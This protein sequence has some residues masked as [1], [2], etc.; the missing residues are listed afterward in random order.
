MKIES[1]RIENLRSIKDETVYLD[2]YTCLVGAN[3]AGKSNIINALN[4]F[5]HESNDSP[6]N[7]VNLDAE[8]FH[9]KNVKEPIIITLTFVELSSEAIND[10]QHY[11]RQEK[12]IIMAKATF[13][14]STQKASVIQYGLRLGMSAFKEYFEADKR[15]ASASELKDIYNK[16]RKEFPDLPH[17]RTKP[18]ME[19]NLKEYE[20]N[21]KDKCELIP[22]EDI[23]YGVSKGKNRLENHIQWIF[24]PAV[25]DA[26]AEQM[27]AKNTALGRLLSR[28][29]RAKT[30]FTNDMQKIKSNALDAYQKVLESNQVALEEISKS[31][32]KRIEE[33]AH[34]NASLKLAWMQDPEKSINISD[35]FAKIIAGEGGFEGEICRFGHGL[36]RSFLLALLQE[37]AS[38]DDSKNPKLILACEEPELYQH[39]PQIRHM[40]NLLQGLSEHNS[41]VIVCTH[42]PS[43]V[44]GKGFECV[45]MI[46][47]SKDHSKVCQATI[48]KINEKITGAKGIAPVQNTGMMAKI[49]QALQPGINEIFFTTKPILVEGVEDVAYIVTYLNLMGF[50]NDFRKYGCHIINVNGKSN[51]IAPVAILQ[52]LNIPVFSVF[53]SDGHLKAETEAEKSKKEKQKKDNM[54]LLNLFN[55]EEINPFPEDTYWGSN[56]VMWKSDIGNIFKDEIGKTDLNKFK[57][58]ADKEYGQIGNLNKNILHIGTLIR[59]AWDGDKK[60]TSLMKLCEEIIK[61]G[62][63]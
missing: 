18:V 21:N 49:H 13:D 5:F 55:A 32:K 19:N 15:K 2:D 48:A 25:K 10:F 28:T 50:W 34:P 59:L 17:G 35:P 33:W 38:C 54:V 51:L 8:D 29:V 62:E 39:P 60:S 47:K 1:I 7:L 11:Y 56:I 53:D 16:F 31:L 42:E 37:L 22:S 58:I 41:Q 12:L 4:I 40:S 30:D 44:T 6:T 46:S 63:S 52:C 20:S 45:R 24:I 61:Y 3:G 36:Q 27:E 57:N 23:F 14:S 26:S 43:L 9:N